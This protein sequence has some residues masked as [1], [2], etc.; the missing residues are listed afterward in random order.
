MLEVAG[1]AALLVTIYQTICVTYKQL[2]SEFLPDA[3][4]GSSEVYVDVKKTSCWQRENS[5]WSSYVAGDF[6]AL[7]GLTSP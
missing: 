6:G 3:F 7:S 1:S 4:V 2:E 5:Q